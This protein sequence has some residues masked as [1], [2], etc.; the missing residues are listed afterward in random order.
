MNAMIPD[1]VARIGDGAFAYCSRLTS[2]TIPNSVTSIGAGAFYGCSSLTSVMIP[3]GVTS[4]GGSAFADCSKLTTAEFKGRSLA[5]VKEIPD[6]DGIPRYSWGLDESVIIPGIVEDVVLYTTASSPSTWL[7]S[8]PAFDASTGAFSGFAEK[9]NAAKVIIPSKVNEIDVM[10]ISNDTFRNCSSLTS[11]T[12]P[13]GVTNIGGSVF[14]GCTGLASMTIPDSVT[15]IGGSAFSS[16]SGLTRVAI[17]NGVMNIRPYAFYNCSGLTSMTIP[18]NM[19][20]I[21]NSAF[22]NCSRIMSIEFEGNAPTTGNNTF[23]GV[24]SGCKAIISPTAAGFP[25]EGQTWNGLVV[26]VK[27]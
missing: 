19:T 1:S 23:A 3:D 7:E 26:E 18:A 25:E 15:N 2:V 8:T 27:R 22:Q 16:C 5:Q 6:A 20:S 11:V 14:L 13:D 24:A 21:G 10:S 4:I 12:I 17:G 9:A